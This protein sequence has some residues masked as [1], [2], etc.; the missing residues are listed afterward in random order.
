MEINKLIKFVYSFCNCFVF[1]WSD[2]FFGVQSRAC[3]HSYLQSRPWT[4]P[5]QSNGKKTQERYWASLH[6]EY[7]S[8][9][10]IHLPLLDYSPT[11]D[12]YSS[13]KTTLHF[14]LSTQSQHSSTHQWSYCTSSSASPC[15]SQCSSQWTLHLITYK[16]TSA[17]SERILVWNLTSS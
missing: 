2:V 17:V 7:H 4:N 11:V 10:P 12:S 15:L 8:K 3:S 6:A 1:P 9:A 5:V 14:P 16:P 13:S